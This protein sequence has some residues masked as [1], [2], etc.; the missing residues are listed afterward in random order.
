MGTRGNTLF[1]DAFQGIFFS[2]VEVKWRIPLSSQKKK[3]KK[4]KH[5][6]KKQKN[7][8]QK[9]KSHVFGE[10]CPFELVDCSKAGQEVCL[11]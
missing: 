11:N 9:K 1:K 4:N 5:K 8:L 6:N 2:E 7:H 10:H 3:Q